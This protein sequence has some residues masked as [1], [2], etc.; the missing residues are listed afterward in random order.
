[1]EN[2][3]RRKFVIQS[4]KLLAFIPLAGVLGC[5]PDA[6][7]KLSPED[8]L[9]R[10]IYII[11]PWRIEDH[12]IAE[13]FAKRFLNTDYAIQYLP[14]SVGLIQSLSKQIIEKPKTVTEINLD[15]LTNEEQEVLINL[16]KQLYSFVEVRFYTSNEPPWGQCQ[17]NSKWHTRIPKYTYE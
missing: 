6:A 12:L 14:K 4:S 15:K 9:K 1:M 8:S 11:G 5:I 2:L 7:S 13:D 17:G 10:I 3:G 16:S